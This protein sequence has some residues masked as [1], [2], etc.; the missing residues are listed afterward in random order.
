MRKNFCDSC[1]KLVDT[2]YHICVE[3]NTKKCKN[4]GFSVLDVCEECFKTKGN[5]A[6]LVCKEEKD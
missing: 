2:F 3:K 1:G 5:L 6:R 4:L